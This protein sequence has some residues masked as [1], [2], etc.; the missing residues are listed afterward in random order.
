MDSISISVPKHAF[1]RTKT[2]SAQS[3]F[4]VRFAKGI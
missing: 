3:V 2:Q 1:S 4:F